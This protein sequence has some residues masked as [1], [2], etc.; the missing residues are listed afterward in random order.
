MAAGEMGP[1]LHAK[2]GATGSLFGRGGPTWPSFKTSTSSQKNLPFRLPPK[3][4]PSLSCT[5]STTFGKWISQPCRD[6]SADL[7]VL[8]V[9]PKVLLCF[10]HHDEFLCQKCFKTGMRFL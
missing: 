7:D 10:E 8:Q 5:F 2:T 1:K 3:L 9:S 6:I 4:A